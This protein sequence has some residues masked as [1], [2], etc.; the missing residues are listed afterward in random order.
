MLAI[1]WNNHHHLPGR[2]QRERQRCSGRTTSSSSAC[3]LFPFVTSW[4]GDYFSDLAPQVTF[5]FM[6]MA[7]VV[8]FVVAPA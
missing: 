6:V 2:A 3:S 7:D 5:G 8:F 1:Y 4:M